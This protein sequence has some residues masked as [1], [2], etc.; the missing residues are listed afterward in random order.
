MG[1]RIGD[2]CAATGLS[3]DTLRFYERIGLLDRVPRNAGG[4]RRYRAGD[5]ARLRF[6]QRAQAMDFSLEEIGQLLEMRETGGDV[7]S[8]VRALTEVRLAD[9]EKRIATLVQLRDELAELIA[10][11]RESEHDCPII[12]RMDGSCCGPTAEGERQ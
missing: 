11:C 4:Q 9:V 1:L 5:I 12:S 7:R 2:A 3:A 8:D 10:A 6:V